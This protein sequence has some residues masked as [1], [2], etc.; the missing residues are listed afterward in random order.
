MG[1]HLLGFYE[2]FPNVTLRLSYARFCITV[3]AVG[4][5]AIVLFIIAKQS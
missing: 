5:D 2:R 4:V 3:K 1:C